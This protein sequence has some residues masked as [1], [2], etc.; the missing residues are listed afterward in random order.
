M[1]LI[2]MCRRD[3]DY[4]IHAFLDDSRKRNV[5][6]LPVTVRAFGAIGRGKILMDRVCF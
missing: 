5:K 4:D 6:F 3:Y 2:R 1:E